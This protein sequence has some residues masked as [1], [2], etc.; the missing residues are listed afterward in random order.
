[1]TNPAGQGQASQPTFSGY[2]VEEGRSFLPLEEIHS[3]EDSRP[4]LSH[5][6]GP[7]SGDEADGSESPETSL[8]EEL[9][10]EMLRDE[11]TRSG[12]MPLHVLSAVMTKH[13]VVSELKR[14]Y[15]EVQVEEYASL[16]CPEEAQND[17][18]ATSLETGAYTKIFAILAR[19]NKC[20]DIHG[21]VTEHLSDEK[22]PFQRRD[23]TRRMKVQ[24]PLFEHANS[25]AEIQACKHW[26]P[27]DRERFFWAQKEF[28][29]HFFKHRPER[30]EITISGTQQ[31]ARVWA[32]KLMDATYLPWKEKRTS[33]EPMGSIPVLGPHISSSSAR[34]SYGSVSPFEVGDK[35][36]DFAE[37]LNKVSAPSVDR[38]AG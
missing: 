18:V 10:A 33:I 23:A 14:H 32:V 7:T 3:F 8:A 20:Q 24:S 4:G 19:L 28:L 22:L 36:H 13:R 17:A 9:R 25:A 37:L 15:G 1:M 30:D 35:D 12:Y 16:I 5:E 38:C 34:G 31:S 6:G 2:N 21:F 26:T 29:V 27:D 11:V